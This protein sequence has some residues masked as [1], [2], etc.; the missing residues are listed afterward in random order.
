MSRYKFVAIKLKDNSYNALVYDVDEVVEGR[1]LTAL[2]REVAKVLIDSMNEGKQYSPKKEKV[3]IRSLYKERTHS[4]I[5]E[6]EL[7]NSTVEEIELELHDNNVTIF[8]D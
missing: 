8:I 6:E 7:M 3:Y 1:T 5:S 2:K 4:E